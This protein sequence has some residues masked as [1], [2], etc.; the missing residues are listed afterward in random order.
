MPKGSD[1]SEMVDAL[2]SE[3]ISD[4]FDGEPN[5]T[6]YCDYARDRLRGDIRRG[7]Q[8]LGGKIVYLRTNV[9]WYI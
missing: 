7:I 9:N 1:I 4:C 6:S 2:I 8:D 3:A 5:T